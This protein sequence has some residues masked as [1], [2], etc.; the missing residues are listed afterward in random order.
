MIVLDASAAYD[1]LTRRD[2]EAG[3]VTSWLGR[4][5]VGVHAPHL[6][7]VEVIAALRR[8]VLR[9]KVDAAGAEAAVA[10][11]QR[12]PLTRYP[13]TVLLGRIWELRDNLTAADATYVALAEALDLPLVTTDAA[14]GR[15]GG[16]LAV[17]YSFPE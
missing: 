6:I 8:Q 1:L 10:A 4:A 7:D 16:H 2:P 3:W 14:L 11:L 17:V 13:H 5:P 15:S 12:M 9:R